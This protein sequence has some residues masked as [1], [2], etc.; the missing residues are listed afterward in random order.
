MTGKIKNNHQPCSECG[1]KHG[2]MWEH[3][4]FYWEILCSTCLK[5]VRKKKAL[6][7]RGM[8][9]GSFLPAQVLD[10]EP[11]KLKSFRMS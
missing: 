7:T 11:S 1:Q 3:P 5:K 2:S 8:N 9:Q 6:A 10:H 4:L